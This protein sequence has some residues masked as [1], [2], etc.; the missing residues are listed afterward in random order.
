MGVE[1]N[2]VSLHLARE[3][4]VSVWMRKGLA[5]SDKTPY[6]PDTETRERKNKSPSSSAKVSA[7]SWP[8]AGRIIKAW[9]TSSSHPS[10]VYYILGWDQDCGTSLL[11]IWRDEL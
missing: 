10:Y 1:S 8:I 5:S 3:R 6:I 2:Q 4:A 11:E 7:K 9:L